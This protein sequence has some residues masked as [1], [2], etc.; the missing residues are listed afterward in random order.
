MKG[1]LVMENITRLLPLIVIGFAVYWFVSG[2]RTGRSW[3][4]AKQ[5]RKEKA[6]ELRDNGLPFC[7]RCYSPAAVPQLTK[8]GFHPFG[9]GVT[10][11]KC[12]MCGK[13][14]NLLHMKMARL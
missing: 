12:P 2:R 5:A 9:G 13:R 11:L 6:R 3:G 7:P 1:V 8:R 10:W 4:Q 14:F